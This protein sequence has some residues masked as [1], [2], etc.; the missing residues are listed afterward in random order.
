MSCIK[1][2]PQMGLSDNTKWL[3]FHFQNIMKE[4][5]CKWMI[6]DL[7]YFSNVCEQCYL[8]DLSDD[9]LNKKLY[10]RSYNCWFYQYCWTP[11]FVDSWKLTY[12][13]IFV[14]IVFAK[15]CIKSDRNFAICCTFKFDP[16]IHKKCYPKS[17]Y[18]SRVY[19][20]I[21]FSLA[22]FITKLNNS[23][24][25]IYVTINI[26]DRILFPFKNAFSFLFN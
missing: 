25:R 4:T 18:E 13:C 17:A 9:I 1:L 6:L 21:F 14:L 16:N 8:N 11:I 3:F 10:F 20:I 19:K 23:L 12:L 26:S 22:I 24:R 7:L 15:V 5:E 2:S